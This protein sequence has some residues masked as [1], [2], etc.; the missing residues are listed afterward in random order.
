MVEA[1]G[2]VLGRVFPK[3]VDVGHLVGVEL[4]PESAFAAKVR[5]AALH[6]DARAGEGDR[7]PCPAQERG[8]LGQ[9]HIGGRG[10]RRPAKRSSSGT[11]ASTDV[12]T[13]SKV[14][15]PQA[16]G[17]SASLSLRNQLS[18]GIWVRCA[19]MAPSF[20]SMYWLT[21]SQ[22][23]TRS[24]DTAKGGGS[25]SVENRFSTP[26]RCIASAICR[27]TDFGKAE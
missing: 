6:R 10:H 21:S 2:P 9:R 25:P 20:L 12:R 24:S 17:P 4:G 1:V 5:D 27:S 26:A 3:R 14:S 13:R 18:S 19:R 22:V 23:V 16:L 11:G 7:R 15:S 8:G